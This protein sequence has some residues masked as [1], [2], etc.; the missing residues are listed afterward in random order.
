M[1][2][3]WRDSIRRIAQQPISLPTEIPFQDLIAYT[4]RS[5]LQA[6]LDTE[7]RVWGGLV[8]HQAGKVLLNK[9][10]ALNSSLTIFDAEV[11]TVILAVEAAMGLPTASL[12]NNLWVLLENQNVASKLKS[13][14]ICSSQNKFVKFAEYATA[15]KNR[16][17]LPHTIT[18]EIKV[19]W[20]PVHAGMKGNE[21]VN[22]AAKAALLLPPQTP[23]PLTSAS[24]KNWSKSL[25]GSLL[26]EFWKLEALNS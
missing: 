4:D 25:S 17:R 6:S 7:P 15:W 8:I 3:S 24:A 2:E 14:P 5:R 13:V 22:A 20:I 12:A 19:I 16:P 21:Q 23:A 26:E 1:K 18:G 10:V 11:T 9:S